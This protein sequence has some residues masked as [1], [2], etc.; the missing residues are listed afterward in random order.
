MIDGWCSKGSF[1]CNGESCV[2]R[3]NH[4][5]KVQSEFSF[6][7][8]HVVPLKNRACCFFRSLGAVEHPKGEVGDVRSSKL[9][10]GEVDAERG[11]FRG[12]C[13]FTLRLCDAVRPHDCVGCSKSK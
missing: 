3:S 1:S 2:C 5:A 9:V 10:F 4:K 8:G 13:S 11:V 6:T 12:M 7:Y